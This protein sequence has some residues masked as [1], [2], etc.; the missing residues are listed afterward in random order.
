MRSFTIFAAL[1]MAGTAAAQSNIGQGGLSVPGSSGG[2]GGTGTVTGVVA[3]TCLTGGTITSSGTIGLAV[4]LAVT[5]GGSGAV[6]P[7]DVGGTGITI[8]GTWPTETFTSTGS[9]T[10]GTGATIT[11]TWPNLTI[12]ATGSGGSVTSVAA[13]TGVTGGTITSTGTIA[14]DQTFS[15][16]WSGKDTWTANGAASAPVL[17]L[18][19][20]IFTGGSGTTTQPLI[21]YNCSG[22]GTVTTWGTVGTVFGVNYCTG[23]GADLIDFRINGG[24]SIFH[25]DLN[26]GVFSNSFGTFSTITSSGTIQGFAVVSTNTSNLATASAASLAATGNVSGATLTSSGNIGAGAT[27]QINWSGREALTSPAAGKLQLGAQDNASPTSHTLQTQNVAAGTTNTAAGTL[28]I[29]G[30]TGT[31]SGSNGGINIQTAGTGAATTVQNTQI[32]AVSISAGSGSTPGTLTAFGPLTLA[33][34]ASSSAAQT[35][36]LCIGT[37]N[38]ISYD[39]TT[40]CLLSDMDLKEYIRRDD[41]HGLAE[42]MALRPISYDVKASV[43]P[44]LHAL[45]RQVGLGAQE[46]IKVDPRLVSLYASGPKKGKPSGVRYEQLTAV[47]VAAI[48]EQQAEIGALQRQLAQKAH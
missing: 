41:I 3:G 16:S 10:A 13:G 24:S 32:T 9:L 15:H 8:T 22:A 44:V 38:V 33:G 37:G 5:C 30:E 4:P 40:T 17:T 1:A 47:L 28:T 18:T 12:S 39:T 42:A 43:S 45:G 35:G 7:G 14:L 19:G 48:Q 23:G 31:G 11:G 36:T 21:Y 34:L 25:V 46:V 26:G 6:T 27:S 20:T 2:G 29:A